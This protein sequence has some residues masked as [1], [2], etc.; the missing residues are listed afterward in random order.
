MENHIGRIVL[1]VNDYDEAFTFYSKN[2]GF[3]K[4]FDQTTGNGQR[5]LHA[6][7]AENAAGIWFLKPGTQEQALYVGKQTAGQP[8]MVIYTSNITALYDRLTANKVEIK[9]APVTSPG[10]K[11]FHCLDLYGNEIVVVEL[12]KSEQ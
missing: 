8:V 9:S 10:Y 11:Y 2:F 6:G 7:P 4:L 12:E 1:L 5:L 3:K